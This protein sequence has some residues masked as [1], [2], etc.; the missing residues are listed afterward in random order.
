MWY[1]E[2]RLRQILDFC[3]FLFLV[4]PPLGFRS[5]RRIVAS[6]SKPQPAGRSPPR[7]GGSMVPEGAWLWA[8]LALGRTTDPLGFSA[9]R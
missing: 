5:T 9:G 1:F 3:M 4:R 7:E 8:M 6:R 2:K